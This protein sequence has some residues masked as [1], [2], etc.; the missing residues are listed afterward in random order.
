ME[1]Q[2]AE[3]LT[4][5]KLRLPCRKALESLKNHWEGLV[6]FVDDRGIPMDNNRSE[7]LLRGPAMGRKNYFGSGAKWSGR[8]AETMFSILATLSCWNLNPRT[9]LAWYFDACAAAGS[10][11]TSQRSF[12][13]ISVPSVVLF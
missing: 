7:R 12:P 5:A 1:T 13:G 2:C 11:K 9:W 6:R 8:L 3:A 10:R 4:D